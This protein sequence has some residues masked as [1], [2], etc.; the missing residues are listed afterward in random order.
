VLIAG[1]IQAINVIVLVT[2]ISV[3]KKFLALNSCGHAK[4]YMIGEYELPAIRRQ[5]P[6]KSSLCMID[7]TLEL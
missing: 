5:M 3:V 6:P 2:E 1:V 4:L 7:L